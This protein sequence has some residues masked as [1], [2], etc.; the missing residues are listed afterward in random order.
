MIRRYRAEDLDA[1]LDVWASASAVGHPF[2]DDRVL[3]QE[4]HN[5]RTVYLP[6]SETWVWD[7]G[8]GPVAFVSL[9]ENEIGA[10][11]VHAA[12][13]RRGIGRALLEHART[14]RGAVELEVFEA[15]VSGRAFYDACGFDA[16]GRRHHAETGRWM[17][18]LRLD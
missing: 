6:V 9:L 5:V 15:N 16:V 18:R 7:E 13:H 12:H 3:A 11:F 14:G 4:R 10:L 17:L 8:D 1:V 2:L